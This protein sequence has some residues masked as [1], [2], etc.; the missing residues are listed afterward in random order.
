VRID[1]SL[2]PRRSRPTAP[3]YWPTLK[4]LLEQSPGKLKRN[5]LLARWPQTAERP[6]KI[7]LWRWLEAAWAQGQLDRDGTGTTKEPFRYGLAAAVA[8]TV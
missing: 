4:Q 6:S 3:A 1:C 5:E 8:A 7:T 2:T